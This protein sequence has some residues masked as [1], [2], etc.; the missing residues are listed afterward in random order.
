MIPAQVAIKSTTQN[1]IEIEDIKDDLVIL[2]DGSCCL[3]IKVLAVN[4]GLLSE[5]EQDA[6]I[7]AYAGLLNSLTFAIQVVIRSKR[8]DISAYLE[9]LKNAEEKQLSAPLKEQIAKYRQFVEN[10]VKVNNVLDKK[11][12]IIIPF[13]LLELGAF[14]ATGLLTKKKGLPYPKT[15]IIERAKTNLYPKRDHLLRQLN[16]VGLRAKQLTTPELIQLFYDIF[17]PDS[18]GSEKIVSASE[19]FS[20]PLVKTEVVVSPEQERENNNV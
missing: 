10:T 4:F 5:T 20:S 6:I 18:T 8:K 11:F 2:K 19:E 9:L 1:F 16:R 12:Y 14:S 7:Y 13:S 15:Q 3:I 17:N